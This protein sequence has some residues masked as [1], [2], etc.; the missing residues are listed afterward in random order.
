M[1]QINIDAFK[2]AAKKAGLYIFEY[3]KSFLIG[4][5][6]NDYDARKGFYW[7]V[8]KD[9][10]RWS[11]ECFNAQTEKRWLE[12]DKEKGLFKGRDKVFNVKK[13]YVERMDLLK[14]FL[15]IQD[16]A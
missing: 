15:K 11:L 1:E 5:G 16:V 2:E 9:D 7:Q 12:T 10:M 3:E 13:E 14:K 6:E 4:F 8:L